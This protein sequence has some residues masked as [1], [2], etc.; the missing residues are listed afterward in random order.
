MKENKLEFL[1]GSGSDFGYYNRLTVTTVSRFFY[2]YSLKELA[3]SAISGKLEQM[4]TFQRERRRVNYLF[5]AKWS[6]WGCN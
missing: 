5:F 2:Q 4:H 1:L 6:L 3:G